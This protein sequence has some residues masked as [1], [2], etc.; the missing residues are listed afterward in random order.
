MYLT[1][2]QRDRIARRAEDAG[3]SQAEIIRRILDEALGLGDDIDDR[4]RAVEETA[5]VLEDHPSWPDWLAAV[6]GR[7]TAERLEEMGL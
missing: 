3:V 4:L 1:D 7:P 6:R 5:G 2:E